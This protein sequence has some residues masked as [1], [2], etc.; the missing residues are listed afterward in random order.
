LTNISIIEASQRLG[1]RV[2]TEYLSGGPF[3]YSYQEMGP[4]RFPATYTVAATNETININ[5]HQMVFFLAEELNKLNGRNRNLSVDFIPWIQNNANGLV[6]KN[7]FKL[8]TGLPPT[9]AQIAANA[10]LSPPAILDAQTLSLQAEVAAFMSNASFAAD[11]AR[12]M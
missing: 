2:H 1:G 8:G 9:I 10:S 5:D 11:M 4:M 12:N 7:G 6:Y 3:N